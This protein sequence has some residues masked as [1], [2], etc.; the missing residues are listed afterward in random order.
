LAL[1]KQA[2]AIFAI[3]WLLLITA[4]LCIPGTELPKFKWD[5]KIF[6]D[7][8]IHIFLFMVLVILW[9]RA[10][11][12][13]R[14]TNNIRKT[15]I[16]IAILSVMYGIMMEIVQ[17]NFI[18]FRSFDFIDMLANGVGCIAGYFFASKKFLPR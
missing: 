3:V 6:L 13:K 11:L 15:F 2:P 14:S 7:K 1:K 10:Y 9:C 18:P 4:L 8:W 12:Y 17:E 16:I 5:N